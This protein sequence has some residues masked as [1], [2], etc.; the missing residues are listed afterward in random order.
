MTLLARLGWVMFTGGSVVFTIVGAAN[1]DWWVAFGGLLFVIGC[2]AL[3]VDGARS[4][5]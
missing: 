2:V 1:D 5:H 3:F 4:R